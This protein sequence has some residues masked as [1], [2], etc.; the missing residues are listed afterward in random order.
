MNPGPF[1]D[2]S[3]D[4]VPLLTHI[5]TVQ[6]LRGVDILYLVYI[7]FLVCGPFLSIDV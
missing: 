7:L 3:I 2:P 1:S 5:I 6:R 4:S